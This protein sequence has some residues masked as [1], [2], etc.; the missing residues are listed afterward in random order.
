MHNLV[1]NKS[2]QIEVFFPSCLKF[3]MLSRK[4]LIFFK[5]EW[6]TLRFGKVIRVINMSSKLRK[7]DPSVDK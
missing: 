6:T 5:L 4:Q 1:Q 7:K 3:R 2:K